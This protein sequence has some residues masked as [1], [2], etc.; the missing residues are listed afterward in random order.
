MK[1]IILKISVLLLLVAV[2][3]P[4]FHLHGL[5]TGFKT[6]GLYTFFVYAMTR[7]IKAATFQN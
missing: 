1:H 3:A 6:I 2:L 4:V 5:A 7:V